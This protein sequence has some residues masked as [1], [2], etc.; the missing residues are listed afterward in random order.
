MALANIKV[1][2]L[3]QDLTQATTQA[4]F[5]ANIAALNEISKDCAGL[6]VELKDQ[7]QAAGLGQWADAE[8][9][10]MPSTK[11]YEAIKTNGHSDLTKL[12]IRGILKFKAWNQKTS[13]FPRFSWFK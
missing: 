6:I 3:I 5:K 11:A 9:T 8:R 10:T 1:T 2:D 13:T 12:E 7:A 4:E